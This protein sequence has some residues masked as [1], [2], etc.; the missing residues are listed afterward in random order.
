MK[1]II[2]S[3]ALLK[4]LNPTAIAGMLLLCRLATIS[5]CWRKL[6]AQWIICQS[7]TMLQSAFI[8][9]SLFLFC[10]YFS[11]LP[12]SLYPSLP[13]NHS[14]S[15]YAVVLTV[16]TE[17]SAGCSGGLQRIHEVLGAVRMEEAGRWV[18]YRWGSNHGKYC[19]KKK[20]QR[21]N[22]NF[23]HNVTSIW[24]RKRKQKS[25][26][27]WHSVILPKGAVKL[28]NI[29]WS[30]SFRYCSRCLVFAGHANSQ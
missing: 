28:G 24:F 21:Q 23:P 7:Y 6:I 29:C 4:T 17:A 9:L 3:S 14:R 2:L 18:G 19:N 30:C 12:S 27:G 15:V 26:R 5:C 10:P 20:Q 1:S 25:S 13:F 8:T 16:W 11:L 22:L